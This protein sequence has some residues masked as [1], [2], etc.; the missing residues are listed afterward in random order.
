M[1]LKTLSR[2]YV[3][4][5]I[6]VL[7]RYTKARLE[8]ILV[9][10]RYATQVTRKQRT[11][12][13]ASDVLSISP[14]MSCIPPWC[15]SLINVSPNLTPNVRVDDGDGKSWTIYHTM[16]YERQRV[17]SKKR[18]HVS[19]HLKRGRF[20]IYPQLQHGVDL[21]EKKGHHSMC[22]SWRKD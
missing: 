9:S 8:T 6:Q 4:C 20:S 18:T 19:Y 17:F 21:D 22:P 12:H 16:S 7:D 1:Y 11:H 2:Y 10:I 14:K 13:E 5:T 3:R 15:Y